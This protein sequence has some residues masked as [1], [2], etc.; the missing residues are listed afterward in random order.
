MR[1]SPKRSPTKRSPT[2]RSSRKI[3]PLM[4]LHT[5][6]SPKM[7]IA[8]SDL[9]MLSPTQGIGS[10]LNK[11]KSTASSVSSKASSAISK[12][13]ETKAK[14]EEL[15]KKATEKGKELEAKATE[16]SN[17]AAKAGEELQKKADQIQQQAEQAKEQYQEAKKQVESIGQTL[18][19]PPPSNTPQTIAKEV[20]VA[21]APTQALRRHRKYTIKY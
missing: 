4:A 9:L 14:A 17:K 15:A 10:L 20:S 21:A 5:R 1:R 12:I 3:S 7:E 19:T 11:A 13:K 2:K 6:Y 18:S 8:S 16:L